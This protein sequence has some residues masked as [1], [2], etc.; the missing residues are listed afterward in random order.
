MLHRASS[1]LHTWTPRDTGRSILPPPSP[2]NCS[3]SRGAVTLVRDDDKAEVHQ[4]CFAHFEL[5]PGRKER[6]RDGSAGVGKAAFKVAVQPRSM[7]VGF[8]GEPRSLQCG[9]MDDAEGA[10]TLE[11]APVQEEPRGRGVILA[12]GNNM[13]SSLSTWWCAAVHTALRCMWLQRQYTEKYHTRATCPQLM[14]LGKWVST[15]QLT[16]ADLRNECMC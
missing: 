12:C 4:R 13:H 6:P 2:V 7:L 16:Y 1:S 8:L 3:I 5:Q 14:L 9:H 10:A 11:A 15:T